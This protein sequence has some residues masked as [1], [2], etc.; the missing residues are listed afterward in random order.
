[1]KVINNKRMHETYNQKKK[2]KELYMKEKT[3]TIEVQWSYQGDYNK[4]MQ[5]NMALGDYNKKHTIIKT[6]AL[7]R[8]RQNNWWSWRCGM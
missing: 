3:K 5:S 4:E 1:M 2:L 8:D 6:W 7:K